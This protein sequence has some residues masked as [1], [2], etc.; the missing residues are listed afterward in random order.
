MVA[1]TRD[2]P[3]MAVGEPDPAGWRAVTGALPNCRRPGVWITEKLLGEVDGAGFAD[4]GHF[5]LTGVLQF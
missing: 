5:D 2:T 3:Q 1:N 4:D